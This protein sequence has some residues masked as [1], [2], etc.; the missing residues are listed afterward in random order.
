MKNVMKKAANHRIYK[1]N[2]VNPIEISLKILVFSSLFSLTSSSP[3]QNK[4]FD[5]FQKI[6]GILIL[7]S[8][9]DSHQV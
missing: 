9:H 7:I 8:E 2:S 1:G 5:F 6:W 3:K 4:Y